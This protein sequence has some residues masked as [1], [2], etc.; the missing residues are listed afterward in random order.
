[1]GIEPTRSAWE[2]EV[3]PLNY[4][5]GCCQPL[6][7]PYHIGFSFECQYIYESFF[8]HRTVS[9]RIKKPEATQLG[10][11]PAKEGGQFYRLL[12]VVT[13]LEPTMEIAS[14]IAAI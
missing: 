11:P 4:T 12:I 6:N 9:Q 7:L 3:L 14:E 1:M 10:H 8:M 5:C 2:A 13:L